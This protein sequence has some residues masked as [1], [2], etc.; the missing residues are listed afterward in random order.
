MFPYQRKMYPR[1]CATLLI[2]E[3]F[4]T[5]TGVYDNGSRSDDYHISYEY[6]SDVKPLFEQDR[7]LVSL[8]LMMAGGIFANS[9]A[10]K[11]LK[12]SN[13]ESLKFEKARL[14]LW[15]QERVIQ[16]ECY[17]SDEDG[18]W[19]VFEWTEAVFYMN[20]P[21]LIEK[22]NDLLTIRGNNKAVEKRIT[23]LVNHVNTFQ[24]V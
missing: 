8:L 6:I 15:Y 9:L 18:D 16:G 13:S 10:L 12:E 7:V 21:D 20:G 4:E 23:H 11:T 2:Y 5:A 19:I 1:Q 24:L 17:E 22:Y 3:L 14:L